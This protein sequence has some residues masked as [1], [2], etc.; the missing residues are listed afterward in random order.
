MIDA[1]AWAL[2]IPRVLRMMGVAGELG[3]EPV[4]CGALRQTGLERSGRAGG[5]RLVRLGRYYPMLNGR[6]PLV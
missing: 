3:Y 6:H 1:R 5:W 4:F 2:P